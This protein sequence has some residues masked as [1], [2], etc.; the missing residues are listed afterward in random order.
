MIYKINYLHDCVA[1][2][3]IDMFLSNE[4]I[5]LTNYRAIHAQKRSN[6]VKLKSVNSKKSVTNRTGPD[7]RDSRGA[8]RGTGIPVKDTAA[9]PGALIVEIAR[10]QPLMCRQGGILEAVEYC[11]SDHCLKREIIKAEFL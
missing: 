11:I 1:T 10:A 4:P 7:S 3:V 9:I 6:L 5:L 2:A 8:G